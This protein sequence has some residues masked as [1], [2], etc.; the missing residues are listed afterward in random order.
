MNGQYNPSD[1]V[2]GN[3]TLTRLIGE[4]S[5][6]RVFEAERKDFGTVYKAAIKIITIPQ[7]QSEI[8]SARAE[9]MSAES[10]T[11]YFR[12]LVE[13]VVHEVALMS[14][15]EGTAN[16]VAYKDHTV[17]EHT[18]NVGWDIIIRMELLTPLLDYSSENAFTRHD[19]IKLG[20][21]ICRALELCQKYNIVH[22]DIKPENIFVSEMGDYKLGDFG[23]AR[24]VEKTTSGLS[25]K[26]T[27]TYMAPEIYRGE[28]YG[29]SVDIYSLGIVLYRL[30]NDNR[31]PFLPEYPAPITHAVR[32]TALVKRISGAKLQE[33]KN[34]DG[35]LSEIV[36]KA[37]SYDAKD[38]YTSPMLMRQ[39]LEAILYIRSEAAIIYPRGDEAPVKS[40]EYINDKATERL[41][42][43]T[44]TTE[45]TADS[46][47]Q[48]V[49]EEN[50]GGASNVIT[51]AQKADG[52]YT[53]NAP[54]NPKPYIP[55]QYIQPGP[56]PPSPQIKRKNTLI[57]LACAI[58]T[59]L[60]LALGVVLFIIYG[61]NGTDTQNGNDVNIHSDSGTDA[62]NG[63]DAD[64]A[65]RE[66]ISIP[67][68]VNKKIEDILNDE[69]YIDMFNFNVSYEDNN[70][71]DVGIVFYQNPIGERMQNAPIPGRKINID[72]VVSSGEE[73][74][75]V[76]PNLIGMYYTEAKKH[77]DGLY[78]DL[79]VID[80]SIVSEV[81]I[82]YVVETRPEADRMISRGDTIVIIHSTGVEARREVIP[83]MRGN[84][85][86]VLASAFRDLGLEP[87]FRE[88]L[89]D[90]PAGTV[91]NIS[92]MGQE[93]EVPTTIIVYISS[94]PPEEPT[95]VEPTPQA[96][97]TVEPTPQ[98]PTTV[99]PTP[100]PLTTVEPTPQPKVQ[101]V[102][103]TYANKE[104]DDLTLNIGETVVL[105]ARVEP[106]GTEEDII[107]TSDNLNVFEVVPTNAEAT[108]AEII[109]IGNGRAVLT[110]SVGGVKAECIIRGR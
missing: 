16:V 13:E 17:I 47:A 86:E 82:G 87:D 10:V 42:V 22:R 69:E 2:L 76:M 57:I 58:A 72:L 11:A 97:A 64:P 60:L 5:F 6:G 44:A 19:V 63:S 31:A 20:I 27:Y 12:S 59:V 91:L 34:A 62:Q 71:Y 26:G 52:D 1:V 48:T 46:S 70:E 28:A 61:G 18:G 105:R 9:G 55:P 45:M 7:S 84:T 29:S 30:L 109:A 102:A 98:P 94:G 107:W 101:S 3:W 8:K 49:M 56:V 110:V 80:G 79:K 106:A 53:E 74:P 83:D 32:E 50:S 66:T 75:Q 25:K 100:Q 43:A 93:V 67:R 38:R 99:E 73:P 21:D 51:G 35:R 85:K 24:T 78:L 15:L 41:F 68:F 89:S 65:Q 96:P 92:K 77:L 95:T 37:C 23:I 36:L 39:E 103:I 54:E 81:E 40:I 33:P 104:R 88:I 108:Q 4:G 90:E 14:R